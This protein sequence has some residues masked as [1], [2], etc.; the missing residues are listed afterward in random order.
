M[1][2]NSEWNDIAGFFILSLQFDLI[3]REAAVVWAD[4]EIA[5]SR[6]PEIELV[7]IS[8]SSLQ[9]IEGLMHALAALSPRRTAA[10]FRMFGALLRFYV[11]TG[12]MSEPRAAGLLYAV[13][14]FDGATI[15]LGDEI[16]WIDELFDEQLHD[17]TESPQRLRAFLE[18]FADVALPSSV[19]R[20]IS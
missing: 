7:N 20:P 11:L 19:L 4:S 8:L 2:L 6:I 1:T 3:S 15:G 13:S 10:S 5:F 9:P 14:R 12:S 16:Y 18:K 17:A